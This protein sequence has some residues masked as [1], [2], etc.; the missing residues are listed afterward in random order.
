MNDENEII[1]KMETLRVPVIKPEHGLPV[2]MA[3]MNATR[4][5]VLG[6]WLVAVPCYF[7]LCVFMYYYFHGSL[8]WFGSMFKLMEGLEKTPYI[9][10]IG[11]I[12]LF[13]LP[14]ISILINSLAILHVAVIK[15]SSNIF[16]IKEINITIKV[17]FWNIF[18]ILL[19]LL[20]VFV[21]INYVFTQN[22]TIKN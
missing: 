15:I 20:I 22:I 18:L 4:S 9:D 1:N 11:P 21:F 12:L 14:L 17:K 8:G 6:V 16:S 7:L 3:I 19:S 13:V 5:A 2:K 10:I